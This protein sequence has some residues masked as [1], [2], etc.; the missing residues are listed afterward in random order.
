MYTPVLVVFLA[1]TPLHD[2]YTSLLKTFNYNLRKVFTCREFSLMSPNRQ[3][4]LGSI[5]TMAVFHWQNNPC[6]CRYLFPTYRNCVS[7]P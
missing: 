2:I 5:A 6:Q 3:T 4:G 7:T 1:T